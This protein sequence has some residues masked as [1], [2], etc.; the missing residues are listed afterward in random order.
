MSSSPFRATTAATA[1]PQVRS[2]TPTTA[3]VAI[4][5]CAS[6]VLSI[7][8]ADSLQPPD[9]MISKDERPIIRYEQLASSLNIMGELTRLSLV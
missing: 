8:R 6:N 1:S 3:T 4:S 5:G 7:S 9:L 2:A